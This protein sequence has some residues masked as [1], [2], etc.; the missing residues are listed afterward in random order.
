MTQN[1]TARRRFR[2]LGHLE[3]QNVV[4]AFGISAALGIVGL[5]L[6]ARDHP[7]VA[8]CFLL[9]S[10]LGFAADIATVFKALKA[11]RDNQD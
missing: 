1:E 10:A 7:Y 11:K 4:L 5:A 8:A 2:A 9:A 6:L 3:M